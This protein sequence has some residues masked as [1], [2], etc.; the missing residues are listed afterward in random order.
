VALRHRKIKKTLESALAA[1]E[2]TAIGRY[3][4]SPRTARAIVKGASIAI[5]MINRNAIACT[6][7]WSRGLPA[8]FRVFP[9]VSGRGW[10]DAWQMG[11]CWR[12][13]AH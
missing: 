6:Q 9:T 13:E 2:R 7:T 11:R 10:K 5:A 1:R 3:L 4:G 8:L 12:E